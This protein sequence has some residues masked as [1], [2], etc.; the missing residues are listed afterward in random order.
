M[1]G[2]GFIFEPL[3][4]PPA[5]G[6]FMSK[7]DPSLHNDCISSR[8]LTLAQLA[9]VGRKSCSNLPHVVCTQPAHFLISVF[10]IH[11]SSTRNIL[12][13]VSLNWH[14]LSKLFSRMPIWTL[15]RDSIWFVNI[16]DPSIVSHFSPVII[17]SLG[18]ISLSRSSSL[19]L[20]HLTAIA[21]INWHFEDDFHLLT[22]WSN[23]WRVFGLEPVFAS[24]SLV[25]NHRLNFEH[26]LTA[27]GW[28]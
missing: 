22:I 3:K 8:L 23:A 9:L 16:G 11:V 25:L 4:L 28:V 12:L 1:S 18:L 7:S 21:C 14:L 5:V 13:R 10:M 2:Y 24:T 20:S 15:H 27:I 6:I 19:A 17:Y 26:L